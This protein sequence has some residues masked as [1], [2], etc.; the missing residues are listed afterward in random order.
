MLI[1]EGEQERDDD[2]WSCVRGLVALVRTVDIGRFRFEV[3][4]HWSVIIEDMRHDWLTI[5]ERE[6]QHQTKT[7]P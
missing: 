2:T 3:Y 1:W 4:C 7:K 6:K 5:A